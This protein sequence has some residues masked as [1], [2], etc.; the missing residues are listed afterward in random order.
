[1]TRRRLRELTALTDQT[2]VGMV[3]VEEPPE[4]DTRTNL[5]RAA[6]VLGIVPGASHPACRAVT[7]RTNREP[8]RRCDSDECPVDHKYIH[9]GEEYARVVRNDDRLEM[10]HVPCFQT[11]FG[12]G[13]SSNGDTTG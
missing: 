8:G 4:Q 6:E 13:L 3:I 11:E 12:E 2:N 9:Y 10:F 1:M 5:Q 7:V